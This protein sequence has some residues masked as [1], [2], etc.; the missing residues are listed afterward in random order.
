MNRKLSILVLTKMYFVDRLR[1]L[2]HRVV[3]F[4]F[5][6]ANFELYPED[7]KSGTPYGD[8]SIVLRGFDHIFDG[9]VTVSELF[10]ALPA[11][12]WPDVVLYIDDSNTHLYVTGLEDL[13]IPLVFYSIDSHIHHEA[14]RIYAGMFDCCLIAQ[15]DYVAEF[16]QMC[17]DS[18]W[19]PLW[20]RACVEPRAARDIDVSFRG[21]FSTLVNQRR[22]D[23]FGALS[24]RF[25][26]DAGT[27]PYS[28]VYSRSKI[29]V[30]QTLRGDLNFRVFEAM[31]CGALL[32][33]PKIGNGQ[34]E[35][36]TAGEHLVEYREGDVE[37]A[38]DRISWLIAH[39]AELERIAAAGKITALSHHSE[40]IRTDQLLEVLYSALVT[41]RPTRHIAAVHNYLLISK[42]EI[43]VHKRQQ[44]AL[45]Y[46]R[47]I[48]NSLVIAA[49]RPDNLTAL[50]IT[51]A[52]TCK[53]L[54]LELGCIED[55]IELVRQLWFHTVGM[56]SPISGSLFVLYLGTLTV[57]G[58]EAEAISAAMRP[59]VGNIFLVEQAR[60]IL[61]A[62][63][64]PVV[65]ALASERTACANMRPQNLRQM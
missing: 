36:F 59:P 14:Q 29:V 40:Q 1:A 3:C 53:L 41:S 55:A 34:N 16:S 38:L 18:R 50:F 19:F 25:R 7:V 10:S 63:E 54:F 48:A 11:D 39:P 15:K 23:F 42:L 47:K 17:P 32:L 43:W 49:Q 33:T 51:Q 61:Q 8:N 21:N 28:E 60:H 4:G 20:A 30:N 37:D 57:L 52:L 2:G 44:N 22:S 56:N 6:R 46:V 65:S 12:F 13:T 27:G 62:L 26:V 24:R 64:Q 45:P 5:N 58:R 31:S 9:E 35:L